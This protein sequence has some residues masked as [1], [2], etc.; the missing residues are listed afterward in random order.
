MF[1]RIQWGLD[2][3]YAHC[4]AKGDEE[5]EKHCE[6]RHGLGKTDLTQRPAFEG[7]DRIQGEMVSISVGVNIKVHK[8]WR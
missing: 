6:D 2:F 4:E 1:I 5:G 3:G 7:S 8:V